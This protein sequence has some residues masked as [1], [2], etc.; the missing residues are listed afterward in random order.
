MRQQKNMFQMKEQDKISEGELSEMETSNLPSKEFKVMIIKMLKELG[1]RM[2]KQSENLDVLTELE[3]I[4]KN[5][6]AVKNTITE[7]QNT[8]EE[9]NVD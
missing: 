1:R 7:I 3:N 9:I 4:K 8:L 6:T 2:D 5:E